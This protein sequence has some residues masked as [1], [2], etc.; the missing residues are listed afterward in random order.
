MFQCID[1]KIGIIGAGPAGISCGVQLKRFGFDPVIFEK[2]QIGGTV[3]EAYKINNLLGFPSGIKGKEFVEK[4]EKIAEK[5]KLKII[6][7]E[8]KEVNFLKN[9]FVLKGE[10]SYYFDILV[11]AS[12]TYPKNF[13]NFNFDNISD[14]KR[15]KDLKIG[16]IGGSDVAFD[17][18]LTLKKYSKVFIIHRRQKPKAIEELKREVLKNKNITYLNNSKIKKIQRTGNKIYV[19]IKR[20]DKEKF[21]CFDFLFN[22]TGRIKENRFYHRDFKLKEKKLIKEGKL[23]L[24]GDVAHPKF[25][26]VSIALGDGVLAAQK[27]YEKIRGWK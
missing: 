16:I 2:N 21:F 25:R 5:F 8:I 18:S 27:I 1:L 15:K 10:N 11:V 24:I 26:Y 20:K 4:I 3:K 13:K 6:Y 14:I 7:E 17:Y 12:G 22:T 19:L 23:Y 9:K